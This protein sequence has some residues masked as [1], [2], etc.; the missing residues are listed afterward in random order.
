[1]SNR[2]KGGHIQLLKAGGQDIF[3]NSPTATNIEGAL[4]VDRY[5]TDFSVMFV[6]DSSNF[7]ANRAASLITVNKQTDIYVTY[8]RGY[9]WR[10]EAQARPLGGRPQQVGYKL[11]S[12]VYTATEYALEHVVDDRQRANAD[13]PIRLDENATTLLT[14]KNM[15]KQDRVWAQRFFTSGV[16]STEF[17][18]VGSTPTGTQFL[19]FQDAASTPIETIDA[20]KERILRATGFMPNT[21][22]LGSGVKRVLRSHP[23]ISDRIKY[24]QQGV[25]DD[26]ILA[27]LFEV[28]NVIVARSVYNSAMEGATDSFQFIVDES[29]MLL[30][31]IDPN[32]TVDSPTAIANF[33]WTGLIPGQTNQ[34]GGVIERGRDDRAHSDYFQGRMAWDLRLVSQD[35]GVFFNDVVVVPA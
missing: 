18:G 31:Y 3:K 27:S 25:A 9:F 19:Q 26:A 34:L 12:G 16:W 28:D 5:L 20:A 1:M 33:A 15:I 24:T 2:R 7:V 30:C 13:E 21:L 11:S 23:D 35:L 32:P 22:V 17:S 14:Q 29:A 8:D 10:D 6:Q 4:H